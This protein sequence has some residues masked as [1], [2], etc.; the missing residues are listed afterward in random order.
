MNTLNNSL[1]PS[2]QI[3]RKKYLDICDYVFA[4]PVDGVFNYHSYFLNKLPEIKNTRNTILKRDS[5]IAASSR[6]EV[7]GPLFAQIRSNPA[8]TY[9]IVAPFT[10]I[11]IDDEIASQLPNNV[12]L[13]ATNVGVYHPNIHSLPIGVDP[14]IDRCFELDRAKQG[15]LAYLNFAI[16]YHNLWFKN[17]NKKVPHPVRE[18]IYNLFSEEAWVTRVDVHEWN[19]YPM[20]GQ[21]FLTQ[22]AKHRFSF[23]PEGNGIDTFRAWDSL[24]LGTIPI[25]SNS[26]HMNSFRG[27]PILF[28][29]NYEDISQEYLEQKANEIVKENF[30]WQLLDFNYWHELIK[31]AALTPV[32]AE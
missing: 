11:F 5:L 26:F 3:T 20:S 15:R 10:D 32:V 19:H 8:Y 6:P 25:V 13:F 28:T 22:L 16:N 23:C 24:Y 18:K 14:E 21:E 9:K 30:D 2:N 27:L 29:D 12:I 31:S 7:L 4:L 17:P 1:I